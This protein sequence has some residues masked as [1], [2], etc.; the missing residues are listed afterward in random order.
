MAETRRR[1]GEA[2]AGQRAAGEI[3]EAV[4]DAR[5]EILA[6]DQDEAQALV[7]QRRA[8][9]VADSEE[10]AA[11]RERTTAS[12]LDPASGKEQGR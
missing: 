2:V 10:E 1:E 4:A 6:A 12:L 5:S 7:Q 8:D 11:R 3:H 9:Q